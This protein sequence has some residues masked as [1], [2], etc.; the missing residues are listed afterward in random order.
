MI[1]TVHDLDVVVEAPLRGAGLGGNALV[2]LVHEMREEGLRVGLVDRSTGATGTIKSTVP[3]GIRDFLRA[4]EVQLCQPGST[5]RVQMLLVMRPSL[6]V[7]AANPGS[8]L[9][10]DRT[11]VI[12]DHED[13]EAGADKFNLAEFRGRMADKYPGSVFVAA[14]DSSVAESFPGIDFIAGNWRASA[15]P[16]ADNHRRVLTNDETPVIGRHSRADPEWPIDEEKIR[17]M[18]PTVGNWD[19]RYY[20]PLPG[21]RKILGRIPQFWTTRTSIPPDGAASID[22]WIHSSDRGPDETWT[23]EIDEALAAGAV[24]ILPRD[25]KHHYGPAAVYASDA[26]VR[27]AV[28]KYH[29]DSRLF[30][31]QS[32]RGLDYAA[33]HSAQKIVEQ[34]Y[35]LGLQKRLDPVRVESASEVR[36]SRRRKRVFFVTSNGAGMGHL[37]RLLAIA[38]KVPGDIEPVFVSFS[39][40]VPVVAGFGFPFVYIASKNETG[41]PSS[42]W[43]KYCARRLSMEIEL[44]SPDAIIF[45]GT[46]PYRGLLDAAKDAGVALVWSRRSMWKQGVKDNA[47]G[48]ASHFDSV[49][50]PGEFAH[51]ADRGVARDATDGHRVD[52][53]TVMSRSEVLPRDQ[54]RERLGIATDSRAALVTLGAGT[55][56]NLNVTTR[57]VVESIKKLAP[58]WQIFLTKNPIA[59]GVSLFDGVR[60]IEEY[61]LVEYSEAFDFAVSAAGYNSFHEWM[62]TCLPTVWLP[63]LETQTDD[64]EA[65]A[66]YA[67]DI[68]VGL[69]LPEP[70][71]E[72]VAEAI[73]E[74]AN[75][76]RRKVMRAELERRLLPNGAEDAANILASVVRRNI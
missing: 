13:A 9:V 22:F 58:G 42:D 63:N 70:T 68:G 16:V 62:A 73:R 69:N 30:H 55:L 20:G 36:S 18:L 12:V 65:R 10:P 26:G 4:T 54:A 19:V 35:S 7:A 5:Y 41:L 46:W 56:N 33:R 6:T 45:D 76:D 57:E 60:S 25:Y 11:L 28:K 53:L 67:E 8:I 47:L 52:P 75:L 38:K 31:A 48:N 32:K 59:A 23:P 2:H 74:I 40:A 17:R 21:V 39:L 49:I 71:P 29:A 15:S 61:P 51:E 43:N 3:R 27:V 34:L 50:Q 24:V 44:Y 72:S 66:Q 1:E 14:A 37:T 64:Q